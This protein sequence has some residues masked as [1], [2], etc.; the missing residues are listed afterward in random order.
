MQR[1][2]RQGREAQLNNRA[3]V[4]LAAMA[5]RGNRL[6]DRRK[7]PKCDIV[8]AFFPTPVDQIPD[9]VKT[10]IRSLV[11]DCGG[12]SGQLMCVVARRALSFWYHD[13]ERR[14]VLINSRCFGNYRL[15]LIFQTPKGR[16]HYR[17]T[18]DSIK[19]ICGEPPS[20]K[21]MRDFPH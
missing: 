8:W 3:A 11:R 7:V 1:Q 4:L 5:D 21:Q 12:M 18:R 10:I 13:H 6:P 20:K 17:L 14:Y 16:Q 9:S 15:R 2:E 19:Q